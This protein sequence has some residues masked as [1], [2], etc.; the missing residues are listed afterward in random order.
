M[1]KELDTLIGFVVV[2][3]VVSLLITIITQMVSSFLGLRGRNL[4]DALEAMIHQIDPQ[5]D[6]KIREAL[7]NRVLTRP[8]ISDSMLSMSEKIW[9]KV[10]LL[11]ALRAGWKQASAIRPDE[12][13]AILTDIAGVTPDRASAQ[14]AAAQQ[15]ATDAKT[16]AGAAAEQLKPLSKDKDARA[17][18]RT[19]AK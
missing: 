14:L 16:A 4:A 7:L 19:K 1:L 3:S 15:A 9:D 6:R 12:L 2:M 13:L 18:A 17:I 8:I 10:P 5:I 11:S